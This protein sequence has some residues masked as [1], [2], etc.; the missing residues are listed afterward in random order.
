MSGKVISPDIPLEKSL[1]ASIFCLPTERINSIPCPHR[2]R[3]CGGCLRLKTALFG[4]EI[5]AFCP[6]RNVPDI[7]LERSS[8]IE[9]ELNTSVFSRM[10]AEKMSFEPIEVTAGEPCLQIAMNKISQRKRIPVYLALYPY[11]D[12]L[13]DAILELLNTT[14]EAFVLLTMATLSDGTILNK[15][16]LR[17]V[18]IIDLADALS[19]NGN[20]EIVVTD[21]SGIKA[22][23]K[24]QTP[25]EQKPHVD[26]PPNTGWEQL[27]FTF[28]DNHT[29][30][31]T[32]GDRWYTL[33]Y[34]EMGMKN[35]AGEPNVQWALLKRF[36]DG[37]GKLKEPMPTDALRKQIQYL[38]KP[39]AIFSNTV[40]Q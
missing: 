1:S 26:L 7:P 8:L 40:N 33:S 32:I 38:N 21:Q 11:L 34:S 3:G 30:R 19:I 24:E 18:T 6:D 20:G 35:H 16:S 14:K 39:C 27:Q 5:R 22:D 4:S 23:I 28:P 31:V 2:K 9:Y 10:V 29:L 37:C 12:K 25:K 15:L 17:G 36:S 13:E